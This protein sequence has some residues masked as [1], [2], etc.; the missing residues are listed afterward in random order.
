[1]K[2][3]TFVIGRTSTCTVPVPVPFSMICLVENLLSLFFSII[4]L[5]YDTYRTYV[6]MKTIVQSF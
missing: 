5:L 6:R 1:M 4:G 2:D 3:T